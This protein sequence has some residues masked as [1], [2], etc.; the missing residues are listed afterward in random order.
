MPTMW[1]S[2]SSTVDLSHTTCYCHAYEAH[3]CPSH[4][5]AHAGHSE[6]LRSQTSSAPSMT[7]GDLL[8]R[9][10]ITLLVER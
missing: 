7:F 10:A 1:I 3:P 6:S 4:P 2:W 8:W 5:T 9:S